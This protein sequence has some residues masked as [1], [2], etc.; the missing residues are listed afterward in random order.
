MRCE[1]ESGRLTNVRKHKRLTAQNRQLDG[2]IECIVAQMSEIAGIR[3]DVLERARRSRDPRFDGKFFVAVLSTGIYCRPTCPVRLSPAVHYYATAAAAAEAGFRPCLRC[4]PEAAPGSPAWIGTS[5]VVR[6]IL[7]LINE[8]ALDTGSVKDL[9]TRIGMGSRHLN[10]LLVQQVGASPV[11][12]A[13]TR[14]LHFAKRLLDET[15]LRA[16]EIA[17]A[18]GYGS[19][20]RFNEAFKATYK[21]SPMQLRKRHP[22]GSQEASEITLKLSYRPPYDWNRAVTFLSE[23]AVLGLESVGASGYARY[24]RTATGHA[25]VRI[26]ARKGEH[27]LQMQVRGAAPAE[28]FELSSRARRVF[29]LTADPAQIAD[30]FMADKLLGPLARRRPGLRVIGVWDPFECAVRTLLERQLGRFAA[31]AV[32]AELVARAGQPIDGGVEGLTRLFPIAGALAE[33]DLSDLPLTPAQQE[34]LRALCRAAR[35]GT[36]CF[37]EPIE[38]MAAA[39]ATVPG[40]DDWVAQ[41]VALCACGEPDAIPTEDLILRQLAAGNATPLSTHALKERAEA[42]RPWRGYAAW[43]LWAQA[44]ENSSRESL[45]IAARST[46]AHAVVCSD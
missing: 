5:A 23:R 37:S 34:T 9:A 7:R 38:E 26:S 42:W 6:R 43:H 29:D 12:I 41:M 39:L 28:L 40:V 35:D 44:E 18:A 17:L 25:F 3:R 4:R 15:D 21:K 36:V 24:L 2:A 22:R 33:A 46:R 30:A 10:R 8:G 45:A 1:G 19:V 14:R 16:T 20:R 31:R 27:A 13:Q 32:A 11:A